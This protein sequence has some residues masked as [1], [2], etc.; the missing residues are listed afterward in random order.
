[1]RK[2]LKHWAELLITKKLVENSSRKYK[3][4]S[5]IIKQ[6][7]RKLEFAYIL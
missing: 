2:M 6:R 7:S 1:M 3:G 5:G 4:T